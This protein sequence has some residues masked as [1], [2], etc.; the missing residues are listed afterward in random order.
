MDLANYILT[1]RSSMVRSGL[2]ISD[3][4]GGFECFASICCITQ[5]ASP[6]DEAMRRASHRKP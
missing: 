6:E 3:S 4:V 5:Q 1:S 2:D